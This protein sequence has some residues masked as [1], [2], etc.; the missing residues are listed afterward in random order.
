MGNW[1]PGPW[2]WSQ[3]VNDWE[4]V[5][6]D[7]NRVLFSGWDDATKLKCGLVIGDTLK[8]A[9]ARL[10][11][12]APELAEALMAFV[13]YDDMADIGCCDV[14]TMI[15]YADALEKARAALAKAGRYE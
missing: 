12:A 14:A 2:F 5:G 13:E 9:D 11:A 7:R 3:G 10:I 1:T 6:A 4:L 15:A 8:E